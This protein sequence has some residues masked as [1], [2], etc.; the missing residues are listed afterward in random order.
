TTPPEALAPAQR[1]LLTAFRAERGMPRE[2]KQRML[3]RLDSAARPT[4]TTLARTQSR[5]VAVS[6]GLAAAVALVWG[7][8]AL[9]SRNLVAGESNTAEQAAMGEV[10]AS[11]EHN[12]AHKP[13]G[14]H[15]GAGNLRG[16]ADQDATTG[17]PATQDLEPLPTPPDSIG[18]ALDPKQ[19]PV[20]D[21]ASEPVATPS[22]PRRRRREQPRPETTADKP[23]APAGPSSLSQER[24][25]LSRAWKALAAGRHSEAMAATEAHA[26]RFASGTL[27]VERRAIATIT[28]CKTKRGNWSDKASVFLTAHGKTPLAPRVREAC[29][30]T[31]EKK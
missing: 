15:R 25:I 31:P 17:A 21:R 14:P 26:Q 5:W 11:N 24:A 3:A 19:P 9:R 23:E 1:A 10:G 29:G 20:T 16:A 30:Q 27:S 28:V 4:P 8:S 12:A 22:T 6:V 2:A 18:P 7:V 13:S